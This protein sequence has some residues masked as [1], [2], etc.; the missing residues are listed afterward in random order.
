MY[1]TA[2]E[3]K[4]W[5]L[6]EC[7]SI[8]YSRWKNFDEIFQLSKTRCSL[9][10]TWNIRLL[11]Q[12]IWKG[13]FTNNQILMINDPL[14]WWEMVNYESTWSMSLFSRAFAMAWAA[15][16]PRVFPSRRR[17]L[18]PWYCL[19]SRASCSAESTGINLSDLSSQQGSP[20]C[21][22]HTQGNNSKNN[23]KKNRATYSHLILHCQASVQG[24]C[25]STLHHQ[26]G[27]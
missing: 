23:K 13:F 11:R 6:L 5:I 8:V 21:L 19:M 18:K 25:S 20:S 14:L 22:Q 1:H 7:N 9:K 4:V 26:H 16:T 27:S 3:C 2:G 17:A 24:L 15:S 10:R 12:I